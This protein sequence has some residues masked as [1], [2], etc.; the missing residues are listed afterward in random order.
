MGGYSWTANNLAATGAT[1]SAPTA[2]P[3]DALDYSNQAVS[4]VDDIE[5]RGSHD[6][7]GARVGSGNSHGGGP[8]HVHTIAGGGSGRDASAGRSNGD[9]AH[10]FRHFRNLEFWVNDVAQ[11]SLCGGRCRK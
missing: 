8:K 11:K 1:S 4:I 9:G 10:R 6:D 3:R 7:F 5:D 2:L